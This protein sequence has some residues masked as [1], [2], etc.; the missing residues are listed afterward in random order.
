MYAFLTD[1]GHFALL[2]TAVAAAA[3][4]VAALRLALRDRTQFPGIDGGI[5]QL[6]LGAGLAGTAI[7]MVM[8]TG[9]AEAVDSTSQGDILAR[10]TAIALLTLRY[11][12]LFA[13][14]VVGIAAV[15]QL[16]TPEDTRRRVP[17]AIAS[18]PVAIVGLTALLLSTSAI[19]AGY[20]DVA[21]GAPLAVA[22]NSFATGAVIG[23]VAIL[24]GALNVGMGVL[25]GLRGLRAAT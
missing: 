3:V 2:I 19:A 24:A 14:P 25:G 7:G 10:G 1:G 6:I 8:V 23:T 12:A 15:V 9:A 20:I 18:A 17:A 5:L 4:P 22:Q 13:G 16:C 21:A 11:G